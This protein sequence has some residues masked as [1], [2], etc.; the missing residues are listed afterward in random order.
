M[1]KQQYTEKN[2]INKDSPDSRGESPTWKTETKNKQK[3]TC[4]KWAMQR[5]YF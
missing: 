2:K 4:K 3:A 5:E 1:L